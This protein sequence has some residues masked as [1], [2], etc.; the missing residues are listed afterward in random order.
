MF[1]L[2]S[3][4]FPRAPHPP[5]LVSDLEKTDGE[6]LNLIFFPPLLLC[7][8]FDLHDDCIIA[9]PLWLSPFFEA[10]C[11]LIFLLY[12]AFYGNKQRILFLL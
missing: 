7:C 6:D 1:L 10:V 8:F 12:S 3:S 11:L 9:T 4:V 2:S 5:F